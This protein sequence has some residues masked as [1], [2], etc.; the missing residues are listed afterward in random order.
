[1]ARFLQRSKRLMEDTSV[2]YI[3]EP[4]MPAPQAPVRERRKE[5]GSASR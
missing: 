3:P 5:S 4:T 1:M 2:E